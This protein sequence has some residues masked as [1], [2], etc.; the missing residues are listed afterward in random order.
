M[1]AQPLGVG[2]NGSI[3]GGV[4]PHIEL[5]TSPQS[6]AAVTLDGAGVIEAV[7]IELLTIYLADA[8]DKPPIITFGQSASDVCGQ[9]VIRHVRIVSGPTRMEAHRS[10]VLKFSEIPHV[11]VESAQESVTDLT[12]RSEANAGSFD[13]QLGSGMN[14]R[15]GGAPV[16]VAGPPS[17]RLRLLDLEGHRPFGRVR[18]CSVASI[19]SRSDAG[20]QRW[21]LEDCPPL[22]H[23]L[24]RQLDPDGA[25]VVRYEPDRTQLTRKSLEEAV[26]HER[27]LRAT[28]ETAATVAEARWETWRHRRIEASTTSDRLVYTALAGVG[29]G[30]RP[31]PAALSWVT[32]LIVVWLSYMLAHCDQF[33]S[34]DAS[35]MERLQAL[36]EFTWLPFGIFGFRSGAAGPISDLDGGWLQAARAGLAIP[37][38]VLLLALRAR[39]RLP[40]IS[41][42]GL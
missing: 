19:A 15:I 24:V 4:H 6:R 39:Y 38:G 23:D 5:A 26:A 14:V 10:L 7:T 35:S 32:A 31:R 13:V 42:G 41:D 30:L 21:L 20:Q 16:T 1:V 29:Y 27:L 9:L 11:S 3:S 37:F 25:P 8:A 36:W 12:I 28:C 40:R 34:D 2:F 22:S 18:G 17:T 33:C